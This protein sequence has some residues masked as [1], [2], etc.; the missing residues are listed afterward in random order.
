MLNRIIIGIFQAFVS[1]YMPV[2]CDQFGSGN[3]KTLMIS[4]IQTASPLGVVLGYFLTDLLKKNY[5]VYLFNFSGR[6]L[7]LC[8]VLH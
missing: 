6:F 7:L 1:I 5:N 4:L 8:K 3:K 2:W